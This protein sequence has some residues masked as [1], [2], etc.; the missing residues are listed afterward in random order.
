VT[1]YGIYLYHGPVLNE[2][3]SLGLRIG[4]HGLLTYVSLVAIT[5]PIVIGLSSASYYLLERPLMRLGRR[6][7]PPAALPNLA[8]SA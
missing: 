4:T 7:R 2:L 6:Q 5:L 3:R 1:S 8:P